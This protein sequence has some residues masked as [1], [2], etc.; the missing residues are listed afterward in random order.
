MLLLIGAGALAG[1]SE[2]LRLKMRVLRLEEFL[3]FLQTAET[4]MRFAAE[5]LFKILQKHGE[6]LAFLRECRSLMEK[7]ESFD[8]AWNHSM[9]KAAASGFS[10][11]DVERLREFGAGWGVTDTEGQIAHC[12]LSKELLEAQLQE[13]RLQKQTK[14]RLY[15]MLGIFGGIGA[16]ILLG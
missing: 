7:G 16:A 13:A 10:R 9:K 2:S 3:R 6:S 11:E 14:A 15:Q 4:A 1:Y 12:R 8:E 5:P